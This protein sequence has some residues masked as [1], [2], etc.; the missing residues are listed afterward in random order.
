MAE[1]FKQAD[2]HQ[3]GDDSMVWVDSRATRRESLL[4]TGN[5]EGSLG[6]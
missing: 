2:R 1:T 6:P 4:V 3:T 5:L